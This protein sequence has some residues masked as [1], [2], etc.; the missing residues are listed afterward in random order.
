MPFTKRYLG[1]WENHFST[2]GLIGMNE[3]SLNLIDDDI[4]GNGGYELAQETLDY[5]R[6][7]LADFQ[8]ETGNFYNLEAT[9]AEVTSHRLA[10]LDK[11]QCEG[12]IQQGE[13]DSVY[14]TNSIQLP[15]GYTDDVFKAIKNQDKLQTKYTGGTVLHVFLG[16]RVT[17]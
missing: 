3:A 5:M 16:E 1:T 6:D 10:K 8:E 13:G 12:I 15:V 4:T 7:R 11:E 2:I 17:D 9:P 14:Y